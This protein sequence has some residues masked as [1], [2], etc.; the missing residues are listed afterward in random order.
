MRTITATLLQAASAWGGVASVAAQLR[1]RRVRWQVHRDDAG[2]AYPCDSAADGN[3]ILRVVN[4]G[5]LIQTARVGDPQEIAAWTAWT[6][7]VSTGVDAAGDVAV[8]NVEAGHSRLFYVTLSGG[9]ACRE[10]A[11]GG[12]SWPTS[13]TVATPG[14]NAPTLAASREAVF[15]SD[16]NAPVRVWRKPW[17]GGSWTEGASWAALGAPQLVFGIG[18]GWN[19]T[20]GLYHVLCAAD[21][22]L[23]RGAYDP[24]ANTWSAAVRLYPGSDGRAPSSSSIRLPRV[25]WV[26][27]VYWCTWREQIDP[28]HFSLTQALAVTSCDW[29]HFGSE[30]AVQILGGPATGRAAVVYAPGEDTIYLADER[31]SVRTAAHPQVSAALDLAVTAYRRRTSASGSLLEVEAFGALDGAAPQS[32]LLAEVL[33]VRGYRTSSGDERVALDPHYLVEARVETGLGAGDRLI[34]RALDGWGLL[35]LG[36]PGVALTYAGQSVRWL[37]A[38]LCARAGLAYGDDGSAGLGYVVPLFQV[39]PHQSA[40]S[41]VRTLLA[42]AGAVARFDETGALYAT[43]LGASAPDPC[44]ALGE[45]GEVRRATKHRALYEATAWSVVGDSAGAA[46]ELALCSMEIGARLRAGVEE[47]RLNTVAQAALY[48][49]YRAAMAQVEASGRTLELPVRPDLELWD[50]AQPYAAGG[51]APV[52]LPGR[53]V[54]LRERFDAARG[55]YEGTVEVGG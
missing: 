30:V 45:K 25:L 13:A 54:G 36:R 17:A 2:N 29:E 18:A 12:G 3:A 6:T 34:L 5:G 9:L 19:P 8:C 39:Q 44:M 40:D 48:R 11:D 47:H 41:A 4:R 21:G 37:L 49:D 7:Q 43:A 26:D 16:R 32:P 51:S 24:T 23:F 46:V 14:A 10:S 28:V 33:L 31:S 20:T 22:G 52:G 53:V 15:W 38:E 50:W 42:L 35:G 27:G 1:D 55:V